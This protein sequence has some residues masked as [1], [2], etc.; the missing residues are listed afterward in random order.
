M[1]VAKQ[2]EDAIKELKAQKASLEEKIQVDDQERTELE[3]YMKEVQEKLEALR[4][5][6]EDSNKRL[7]DL[8]STITETENGYGK[9]VT[10]GKTLME[11][12]SKNMD[13]HQPEKN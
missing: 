4:L 7:D 13:K 5:S 6:I 10:A 12:V 9:L 3:Q 2:I 1:D 8:V 11:I